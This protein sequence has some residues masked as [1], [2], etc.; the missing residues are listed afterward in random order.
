MPISDW[1]RGKPK[2]AEEW[3]GRKRK[4]LEGWE[5][6]KSPSLCILRALDTHESQIEGWGRLGV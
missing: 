1:V 5:R 3:L 4:A 2:G 6:A